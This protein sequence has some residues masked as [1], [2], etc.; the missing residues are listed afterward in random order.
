MSLLC[1]TVFPFN[2]VFLHILLR[3]NSPV[4]SPLRLHAQTYTHHQS[5]LSH[6]VLFRKKKNFARCG[7]SL[8]RGILAYF[9]K[10]KLSCA[11]SFE[12]T[13]LA[14]HATP[15]LSEL[16]RVIQQI[17]DN[18]VPCVIS[19]RKVC[20]IHTYLSLLCKTVFS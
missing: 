18:F 14:I 20:L 19:F 13:R 3:E 10:R 16:Q 15:N 1:N 4:C 8:K 5:F 17:Q 7:I 9:F 11:F 6:N 12:A 2:V